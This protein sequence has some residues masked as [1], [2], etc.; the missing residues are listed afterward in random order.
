MSYNRWMPQEHQSGG[1]LY[2]YGVKG[3]KWKWH[4]GSLHIQE[5]DQP[6]PGYGRLVD[7]DQMP[8]DRAEG[9]AYG[10][11][12][13]YNERTRRKQ[14]TPLKKSYRKAKKIVDNIL[15]KIKNRKIKKAVRP[16]IHK[17]K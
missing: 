8:K 1:E 13:G 7:K 3:M 5:T 6:G 2:H 10:V 16:G 17:L 9:N 14:Q 12:Y 4:K 11:A 15:R